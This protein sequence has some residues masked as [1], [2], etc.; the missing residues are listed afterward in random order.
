MVQRTK[1]WIRWGKCLF[2]ANL[3]HVPSKS[4]GHF[5]IP[6]LR[7]GC[8]DATWTI[9]PVKLCTYWLWMVSFNLGKWGFRA[10]HQ[11]VGLLGSLQPDTCWS[12]STLWPIVSLSQF[13]QCE[14]LSGRAENLLSVGRLLLTWATQIPHSSC[15]VRLWCHWGQALCDNGD[16]D[17]KDGMIVLTLLTPHQ[18]WNNSLCKVQPEGPCTCLRN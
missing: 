9:S 5:K 17:M 16:S 11:S 7:G 8:F 4:F 1:Y 3:P 18:Q 6:F 10:S 14:D 12:S 13:Q 2:P 15:R